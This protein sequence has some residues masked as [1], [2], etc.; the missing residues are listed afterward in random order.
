MPAQTTSDT[1]QITWLIRRLFRAMGQAANER[2]GPLG[3]TAADRAVLEFLHPDRKLSVPEIAEC[4]QVTRQHIQVTINSLLEKGLVQ[5][6]TNPRHKRSPL[7][8][9]SRK[10]RNLFERILREDVAMIDRWFSD[11]PVADCK[12]TRGTLENLLQQFN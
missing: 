9:L 1:Y 4:Y 12:Q 6:R 7:M 2:L 11:I 3:I 10:G 5:S 8:V